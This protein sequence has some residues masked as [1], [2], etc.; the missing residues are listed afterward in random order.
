M[1]FV[2]RHKKTRRIIKNA[3]GTLKEKFPCLNYMRLG[4]ELTCNI[5]QACTA[6]CNLAMDNDEDI[7][8]EEYENNSSD[9]ELSDNE[10]DRE[11]QN[12]PLGNGEHRLLQ[13]INNFR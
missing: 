4:P 8:L 7:M 1:S 3:F 11:L 13:I 10:P 9:D 5:F 6:L 12:F 2:R